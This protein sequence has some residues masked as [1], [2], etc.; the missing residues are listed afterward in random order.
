[1]NSP[2]IIVTR[3]LPAAVEQ[4]L[5]TRY[6]ALLNGDD[7]QFTRDELSAAIRDADIVLCTLT[8]DLS[9]PTLEAARGGRARLLANFGVGFNH[10]DLAAAKELGLSVTNTPGVLT[11][12]TADHTLLLILAVA[13]RAGEGE[14][15]LRG[16]RWTGWRP[17]HLLGSRVSGKTL[18]IIGFGRIGRAVAARAHDGFGMKILYHSRTPAD[19]STERATGASRS[20][21]LESLLQQSDFVSLHCP[22]T[23]DT[24]HLINEARLRE[25]QPHAYLINTSRGDVVDEQAL[26][27]ALD[28]KRIAGAALDVFDGEPHVSPQLL[29]RENVVLLPH[30][31]S[32]TVESRVA[33]G[34]RA[35]ANID[36]FVAQRPLPDR[37][38]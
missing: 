26:V 3:R 16:G 23:P 31:G 4:D 7:H 20:E 1:M 17:T 28:E 15:E 18:G 12:D 30:L 25:M 35:I 21:S 38:A 2:R 13:R 33:M 19:A 36:A 22:A 8:D 14:R 11:E 6:N 29:V 32:A 10:I 34:R 24:R 27:A 37:I 9:R 5:V